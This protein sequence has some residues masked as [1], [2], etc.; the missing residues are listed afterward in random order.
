MQFSILSVIDLTT[1]G[2]MLKKILA[3]AIATTLFA[4]SSSS[5]DGDDDKKPS[6][7]GGS[8]SSSGDNSSSSELV[9]NVLYNFETESDNTIGYVLGGATLENDCVTP[10]EGEAE[11]SELDAEG[12]PYRNWTPNGVFTLKNFS[13]NGETDLATNGGGLILKGLTIKNYAA[14][15]FEAKSTADGNHL[16][17]VKAEKDG[18]GV[19]FQK[20]FEPSM[21][22]FGTI[23]IE[24]G[25]GFVKGY[26]DTSLS[27][28]E[29]LEYVFQNSTEAEFI[30]PVGRFQPNTSATKHTLEIDNFAVALK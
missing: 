6:G 11:C 14:V 2:F 13:F 19:A 21:T 28:A 29:A 12:K 17:R 16:F 26:N 7:G 1:G 9:F 5:D 25:S 27:D 23:T 10:A 3:V 30:I 8:S 18:K 15:K 22:S 4:C 20:S 24:M